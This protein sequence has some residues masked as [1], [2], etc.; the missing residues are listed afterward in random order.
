M[1]L[2]RTRTKQSHP[3]LST[4]PELILLP[5][6]NSTTQISTRHI[7]VRATYAQMLYVVFVMCHDWFVIIEEGGSMKCSPRPSVM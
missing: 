3:W 6:L 1:T 4:Q 5:I 2:H 7:V